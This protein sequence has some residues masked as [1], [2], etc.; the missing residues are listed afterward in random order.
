MSIRDRSLFKNFIKHFSK[1]L[2]AFRLIGNDPLTIIYNFL[3]QSTC[4]KNE[5]EMFLTY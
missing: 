3:L 2:E 1:S 5:I 4:K